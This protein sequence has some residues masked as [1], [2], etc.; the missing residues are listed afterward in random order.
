MVSSCLC[1]ETLYIVS[2]HG[3]MVI[4]AKMESVGCM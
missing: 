1:R 2:V 3:I 4:N